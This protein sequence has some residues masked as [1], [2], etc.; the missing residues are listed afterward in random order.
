MADLDEQIVKISEFLK[1]ELK[2]G[3]VWY[4]V[5]AGWF[6]QWKKYVGFEDCDKT[7]KGEHDAYPGPI[8]NSALQREV[9][10]VLQLKDHL[11]KDLD[12]C[13]LPN[14]GWQ[15]LVQNYGTLNICKDTLQRKVIEQGMFVKHCKVEIY[16][17]PLKL[18]DSRKQQEIHHI[19][20]SRVD[21]IGSLELVMRD[22][23]DIPD[24]V[25]VRLW[26]K[27]VSNTYEQLNKREQ[28]LQ[29]A[30]FY[31]GQIMII[32]IRNKD[33]TWP[34]GGTG[35]G[36][37]VTEKQRQKINEEKENQRQ[38]EMKS[39]KDE[40][41]AQELV[42]CDNPGCKKPAKL[43]CA[44]CKEKTCSGCAGSHL[45]KK[46]KKGHNMVEYKDKTQQ[47]DILYCTTH[48]HEK[49][50]LYCEQCEIPVCLKCLSGKSHKGHD[51]TETSALFDLKRTCVI[52]DRDSIKNHIQ[53][54]K[55]QKEVL[56]TNLKE[57]KEKYKNLVTE[58]GVRKEGILKAV[59]RAANNK[60]QKIEDLKTLDINQIQAQKEKL[61]QQIAKAN[62]VLESQEGLLKGHS[63]SELFSFE[64]KASDLK[65]IPEM[66]VLK[67]HSFKKGL[68]STEVIEGGFG[69][70]D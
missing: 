41:R 59:E 2:P 21:T 13:L 36:F 7:Y 25:E 47:G 20:M 32:E 38:I 3:D 16:L 39:K 46:S 17:M 11:V 54:L 69:E 68:L 57:T 28:T 1:K 9:E 50:E 60:V 33:G 26:N 24:D 56:D 53:Q 29:E 12:Y 65:D 34:R 14:E 49:C 51:Y 30:G 52:K 66:I 42:L 37:R 15:F 48:E 35:E 22:L 45:L 4:L 31:S 44:Q 18:Q 23:F 61:E 5:C 10:G 64:S 63:P 43:H 67:E 8:D 27:Y 70:I 58:V 19:N 40:V 6:K 62:A 55:E